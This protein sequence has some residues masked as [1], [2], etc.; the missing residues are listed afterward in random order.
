MPLL[1]LTTA[2]A[3]ALLL[4]LALK[5]AL[6]LSLAF[7]VV[8]LMRRASAAARHAV[9]TAALAAALVLPVLAVAV[10]GW[11]V[12]LLP[13]QSAPEAPLA[14]PAPPAPPAPAGIAA[15]APPAP[16][17]APAP[18]VLLK[19]DGRVI[20]LEP[21]DAAT[22][23]VLPDAAAAPVSLVE[24]AVSL[25]PEGL[26]DAWLWVLM[27]WVAGAVFVGARWVAAFVGARRLLGM[28]EPVVDL[29]WHEQKERVALMIGLERPVR[30]LRSDRLGVPIAWGLGRP[31]IVLPGDADEWDDERRE[32]VL[33]HELAHIARRDCLSQLV[34]QAAL[35]AHWFN[36]LAW[37]AYRRFMLE[38]EHAC[39][40]YVIAQGAP[41]S[42]YADHLVEIARRCRQESLALLAVAPMARR[43]NLEGRILSILNPEQNRAGVGRRTLVASGALAALLVLPLAA[44]QPVP[45]AAEAEPAFVTVAELP[46][47][48]APPLVGLQGVRVMSADDDWT[49]EGRVP[50][51]GFVEVHNLNGPVRAR[52]ASGDRLRVEAEKKGRG[53]RD[54]VEIVVNEF[55]NGVVVCAVWPGQSGCKP[56]Q[57][58]SGNVRDGDDVNVHLELAVPDGV[59]L[60]AHTVN[61]S[62]KTD[63]PLDG[64]IE[65]VSVN[66][67]VHVA[68]RN[69]QVRARTVNG[70]IKST[71]GG[72]PVR[73]ETVNGS[74]QARFGSDDWDGTIAF[75]TVN[76]SITV[77][78]PDDFDADVEARVAHGSIRTDLPLDVVKGR[79]TG[80]RAS[81]RLGSGG[82]TLRLDA[83]NGSIKLHRA[84]TAL[85][86]GSS[87]RSYSY[88]FSYDSDRE[89]DREREVEMERRA[90]QLRERAERLRG[91]AEER[92]ERR[93][94]RDELIQVY[95]G[96][97]GEALAAEALDGIGDIVALAL[98]EAGAAMAEID[99]G[100]EIAMAMDAVDWDEIEAE[101]EAAFDEAHWE[102]T[103]DREEAWEEA[104]ADLEDALDD[105]RDELDDLDEWDD[106]R[107][108]RRAEAALRGVEREIERAL[109]EVRQHRAACA[110]RD[111]CPEE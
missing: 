94:D 45:V 58:P 31:A 91:E 8:A 84:G 42:A 59:R 50:A 28:A 25:V 22:A 20:L 101:M 5:G 71:A 97:T 80:A 70:S 67:S 69:G 77:E 110:D 79:H 29:G 6:V 10:P 65:A 82:R 61:G 37:M 14:V 111:A 56:G 62:V 57:G 41:A 93:R 39:D 1:D 109:H 7:V 74:I 87:T 47:P 85:G 81:G 46:A 53:D 96:H 35:V 104:E 33:T 64:D 95:D 38:R 3:A 23:P 13:A 26:R 86:A 27:L 9:W 73:A 90:K 100:A 12:P 55:A 2:D 11:Q 19:E 15:P 32:V 17:P 44:F 34:A 83:Q 66:G 21:R 43:S 98:E 107:N 75:E 48:P 106:L 92:Q 78:V 52:P 89:I 68:S 105:I 18:P 76:G 51:G 108:R 4:S 72:G 40:D 103:V 102:V 88:S 16:P 49:W 54:R 99:F 24:Q 36:P 63:D 30:L 60:V